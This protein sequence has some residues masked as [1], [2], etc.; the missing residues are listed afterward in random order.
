M[1]I[2]G[3]PSIINSTATVTP[4]INPNFDGLTDIELIASSNND[5]LDPDQE[6][7][8]LFTALLDPKLTSFPIMNQTTSKVIGLDDNGN[9]FTEINGETVFATD[10]SD[11]GMV[12][13]DT[14]TGAPGDTGTEDDGTLLDCFDANLSITGGDEIICF[15]EA[16]NLTATSDFTNVEYSWNILGDAT[17]IPNSDSITLFLSRSMMLE[18]SILVTDDMC[19]Y[20]VTDTIQVLIND[21]LV[22]NTNNNSTTCLSGNLNVDLQSIVSGGTSPYTYFW[23]GPNGFISN[24]A[25]PSITNTGSNINGEYILYVEDG[26]GCISEAQITEVNTSLIPQTPSISVSSTEVCEGDSIV[27][28]TDLNYPDGTVYNWQLSLI[29]I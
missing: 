25:N 13:N 15:G 24:E 21:P 7:Q 18:V 9:V 4:S 26:I 11:S 22:L 2:V 28:K 29:H 6:I 1:G 8:I 5:I 20:N 14:N 16:V 17:Q 12:Y 10:L 23:T 3:T 27:I 19:L